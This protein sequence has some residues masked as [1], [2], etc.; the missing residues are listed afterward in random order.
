MRSALSIVLIV[1]LTWGAL[2]AAAQGPGPI[3]R[4]IEREA[5]RFAQAPVIHHRSRSS[6]ILKDTLIGA[7]I[8]GGVAALVASGGVCSYCGEDAKAEAALVF[9]AGFAGVGALVGS[10]V[11]ALGGRDSVAMFTK[12]HRAAVA[13]G[14]LV[15]V[16]T[17]GAAPAERSFVNAGDADI[18]VL[19]TA[20]PALSRE[21]VNTLR[22]IAARYPDALLAA[23][24][25]ASR[26]FD[27]VRLGRDGVFVSNQKIVD[28]AQ[29]LERISRAD[30]EAGRST[31]VIP[32]SRGMGLAGR[33]AIG[34]G[35]GFFTSA[36]VGTALCIGR[37]GG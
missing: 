13:P 31:I 28:L 10:V 6:R 7:G 1:S 3:A 29:I 9:G 18:V 8:G 12:L 19:N 21:Q 30:V 35:V 34:A 4:S 20:L 14:T 37:C 26:T 5:A 36:F 22:D 15:L 23:E 25:G 16:S 24:G 33:I 32:G 27:N 11:G 17:R 2:P